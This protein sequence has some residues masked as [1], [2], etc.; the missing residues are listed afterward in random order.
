MN[1]PDGHLVTVRRRSIVMIGTV[2]A[3]PWENLPFQ[4]LS[5]T[6][7]E[8]RLLVPQLEYHVHVLYR[9]SYSMIRAAG[10][11]AEGHISQLVPHRS[12]ES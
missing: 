12:M 8:R 7:D 3:H 10:L 9:L 2:M 1:S 6:S 11:I 5:I 4:H